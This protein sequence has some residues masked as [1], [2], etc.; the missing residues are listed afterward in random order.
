MRAIQEGEIEHLQLPARSPDFNPI[1]HVWDTG[2]LD[3]HRLTR[4]TLREL[5]TILPQLWDNLPQNEI[6]HLIFNMPR[7]VHGTL[8]PEVAI[9]VIKNKTDDFIVFRICYFNEFLQF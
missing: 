7:R 1:Q 6:D 8:K 4:L 9:L 3:N 5:R 2:S